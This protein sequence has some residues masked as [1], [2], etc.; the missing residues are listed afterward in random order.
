MIISPDYVFNV[1]IFECLILFCAFVSS[2]YR[3]YG[4]VENHVYLGDGS[5]ER[6]PQYFDQRAPQSST[7]NPGCPCSY[8]DN[9]P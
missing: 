5:L 8:E 6:K 4:N 7:D 2:G 9:L 3:T 1:L